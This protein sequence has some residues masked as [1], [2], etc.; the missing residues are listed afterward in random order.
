MSYRAGF[1]QRYSLGKMSEATVL[2]IL[3]EYFKR[4]IIPTTQKMCAHDYFCKDYTYEL[5]TRTNSMHC[6]GTTLIGANKL[7][8]NSILVFQ[9][10]DKLAYIEYDAK[11]FS[12]YQTKVLY[13]YGPPVTNVLIPIEHLTVIDPVV[14]PDINQYHIQPEI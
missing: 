7:V 6:Y 9:F 4:D 8:P 1:Q 2:P 10:T 14:K 12:N 3:K 5:K 11:K 13:K